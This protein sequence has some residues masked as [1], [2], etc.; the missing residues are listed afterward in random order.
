MTISVKVYPSHGRV[1]VE[2]QA[3]DALTQTWARTHS[4][5]MEPNT[6]EEQFHVWKDRRLIVTELP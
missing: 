2:F 6:P 5:I 4:R 3:F 1:E